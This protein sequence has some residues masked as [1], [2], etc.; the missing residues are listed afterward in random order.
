[1]SA[2]TIVDGSATETVTITGL[3]SHIA[4]AIV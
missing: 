1:M 3:P 2:I 4:W